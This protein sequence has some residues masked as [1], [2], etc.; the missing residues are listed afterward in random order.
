M[1]NLRDPVSW[2]LVAREGPACAGMAAA[3]PLRAE[4]GAGAVIPGGCF[5]GY[6]FV[7]PDRWGQGIGAALLDAVVAEARR[8]QCWRVQL[9]TA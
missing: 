2:F 1:A 3:K 9:W 8:R 7:V 5:L 4:D 6:L